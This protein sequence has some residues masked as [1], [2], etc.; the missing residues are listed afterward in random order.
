M[1]MYGVF[2]EQLIR[3]KY[4]PTV[5]ECVCVFVVWCSTKSCT[6]CATKQIFGN[7]FH[8]N[9][10]GRA[11]LFRFLL[12]CH[13]NVRLQRE[14][15]SFKSSAASEHRTFAINLIKSAQQKLIS[16]S[17]AADTCIL[18]NAKNCSLIASALVIFQALYRTIIQIC[19][20]VR[21]DPGP[22]IDFFQESCVRSLVAGIR[23]KNRPLKVTRMNKS[24]IWTHAELAA[25]LAHVALPPFQ[26][27]NDAAHRT[28]YN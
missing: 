12:S 2:I 8:R 23:I 17:F 19:K 7:L 18:R 24:E 16:Y 4:K 6:Q 10:N 5:Y 9:C 15:H 14:Q 1:F 22:A 3:C 26:H 27:F 28:S 11:I 13:S 21:F 20:W 25:Q